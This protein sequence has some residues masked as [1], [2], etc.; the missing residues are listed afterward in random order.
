MV[1]DIP[2]NKFG[3]ANAGTTLGRQAQRSSNVGPKQ[4]SYLGYNSAFQ[5][6]HVGWGATAVDLLNITWWLIPE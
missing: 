3:W 6:C 1:E 2:D 4:P 5:E